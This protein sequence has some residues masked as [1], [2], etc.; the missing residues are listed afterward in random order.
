[1]TPYAP[2]LSISQNPHVGD[3][4]DAGSLLGGRNSALSISNRVLSDTVGLESVCN[5]NGPVSRGWLDAEAAR[6]RRH[7]VKVL[8]LQGV[9]LWLLHSLLMQDL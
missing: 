3:S 7:R 4:Y 5:G 6:T 8:R 1:M 2:R 9:G